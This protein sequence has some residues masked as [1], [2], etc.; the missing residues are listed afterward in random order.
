MLYKI[1]IL[2]KVNCGLNSLI[3][4]R[5]YFWLTFFCYHEAIK[6]DMDTQNGTKQQK[7]DVGAFI[8][9]VYR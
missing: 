1:N 2:S 4:S 9:E 7:L 5:I 8:H 6:L 3:F